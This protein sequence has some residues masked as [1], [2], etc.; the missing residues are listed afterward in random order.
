MKDFSLPSY[1]CSF[2]N[3]VLFLLKILHKSWEKLTYR[4]TQSPRLNQHILWY[5][6]MLQYSWSGSAITRNLSNSVSLTELSRKKPRVSL[7]V[8]SILSGMWCWP[9]LAVRTRRCGQQ[10]CENSLGLPILS[11]NNTITPLRGEIRTLAPSLARP[12]S[13]FS[14]Y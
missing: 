6:T 12:T 14:G 1:S 5:C 10:C 2:L 13:C 9:D 8:C 4:F 11:R 3:I 7:I